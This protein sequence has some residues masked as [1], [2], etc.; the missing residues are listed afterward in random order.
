MWWACFG[1][2]VDTSSSLRQP[3][4]PIDDIHPANATLPPSASAEL[5]DGVALLEGDAGRTGTGEPTNNDEVIKKIL[6]RNTVTL[7]CRLLRFCKD[8]WLLYAFGFF[9]LLV[10]AGGKYIGKVIEEV[11]FT[12]IAVIHLEKCLTCLL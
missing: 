12:I 4:V 9:G 5:S 8:E 3:H 2:L 1:R 6:N 10:Y 7:V 11:L